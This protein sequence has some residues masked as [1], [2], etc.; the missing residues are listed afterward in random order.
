MI[1]RGREARGPVADR[2]P[3]RVDRRTGQARTVAVGHGV[4]SPRRAPLR[5]T[6]VDPVRVQVRESVQDE[7]GQRRR[8]GSRRDAP[9][10]DEDHGHPGRLPGSDAVVGVLDHEARA[11]RDAQPASRLEIDIRVPACPRRPRPTRRR[12]RRRRPDPVAASAS[13]ITSAWD[14]DASADRTVR[15]DPPD[16]FDGS[17]D[18]WRAFAPIALGDAIDD[19]PFDGGLGQIEVAGARA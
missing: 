14:E 15:G 11:G 16:G 5:P 10:R 18:A 2:P 3:E 13:P 8:A 17:V 19:R 4:R 1:V 6:R 12:P 7:V 9:V